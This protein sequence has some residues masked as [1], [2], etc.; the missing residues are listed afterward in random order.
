[1]K[2]VIQE[3]ITGCAIAS[4]AAIAGMTYSETKKIANSIGI[5]ADDSKLWSETTYIRN[6]LAKLGIEAANIESAFDAWESVPDVALLSTKWHMEKGK[7]YWHWVVFVRE[8]SESY[9]LA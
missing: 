5:Y 1:M 3:E 4:A 7:A 2:P 9:I 8:E 6:L